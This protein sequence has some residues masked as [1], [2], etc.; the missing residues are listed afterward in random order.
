MVTHF[1]HRIKGPDGVEWVVDD[2]WDRTP[3]KGPHGE[4]G[5]RRQYAESG[6]AV[7]VEI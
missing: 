4:S 1:I 6:T 3:L 5:T 7:T 2:Y